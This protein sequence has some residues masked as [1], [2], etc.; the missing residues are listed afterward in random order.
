MS[1]IKFIDLFAGIGGIRLGLEK[2]LAKHKI[3]SK[4]VFTSEID[5]FSNLTYLSNF[6]DEHEI[7]GD[8]TQINPSAIPDHD[9]LLA[10]FPCQAFSQAGKKRGFED[11]RGTLFFDIAKILDIKKPKFF[12]LENVKR[13]ISHDRKNINDKYGNTFLRIKHVLKNMGYNLYWKVLN[14]KDFGLPQNRERVF[15]VGSLK[16]IDFKFP[17]PQKTPTLVSDILEIDVDSKYTISDKLWNG[18]VERK[19]RNR[20]KGNGFGYGIVNESS[21]HTNTISARYYKDGGEILIEQKNGMNPRKL[22]PREAANLQGFPKEFIIPVSD[23]QS[24]KQ[25]G[26]SVSVPIIESIISSLSRTF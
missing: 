19:K 23:N 18:H 17:L 13:L 4:C 11:V 1:E 7:S 14:A 22:T 2:A 25:F 10:G 5:K 24:Y 6:N 8:I 16:K 12:L 15:I 26:N 3:K 21:T 20:L 9:V